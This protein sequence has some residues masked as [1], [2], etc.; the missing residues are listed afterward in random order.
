MPASPTPSP[1]AAPERLPRDIVVLIGAALIVAL[2]F[3]L[4]APILPSYAQ[5]FGVS[6]AA[7]AA[8]VSV[9]AATRLLFAPV[10][11]RITE[12]WGEPLGYVSGVLIVAASTIACAFATDYWSLI[13]FRAVGGIGSTLFTV[14]AGSFLARRSPSSLRGRVA[15]LYGGAFLIGNV[16]GPLVGGL[17]S[18]LGYRAPFLIYGVALVIAAAVVYVFLVGVRRSLRAKDAGVVLP[19]LSL[20]EA[21]S[22]PAYRAA[23]IGNFGNGWVTFGVRTSLVPLFAAGALGMNAFEVGLV[24]TAFALGNAAALSFSGRWSDRVG[25]R[26]PIV[27]GMSL[28]AITGS[29]LGL[30]SDAWV[31]IALS[32]LSG[33][34]TGMFGPAQQATIADTVGPERSAGRAMAAFQMAADLPAIAAPLIAG[35]LSD[36]FGYAPAFAISGLIMVL[37]VIAWA[38]VK[39]AAR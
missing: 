25:R 12:R 22:S 29:V 24:L 21:W 13:V 14:S 2:G 26:L 39:P 34:G 23:M 15:G 17:L 5:S 7:A 3:G 10:S 27:I 32:L 6:N 20:R 11:G 31:L 9:F 18:P 8:I 37:G 38:R 16:A 4:I 35:Y 36:H 28:A 1:T 30:S 33:L 19:P